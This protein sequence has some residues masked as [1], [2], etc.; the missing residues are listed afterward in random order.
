LLLMKKTMNVNQSNWSQVQVT[1]I[2][3]TKEFLL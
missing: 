2:L 1:G 3:G